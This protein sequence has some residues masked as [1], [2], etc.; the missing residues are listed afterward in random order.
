[1]YLL[2]VFFYKYRVLSISLLVPHSH[3]N[4]LIYQ[5]PLLHLLPFSRSVLI[6]SFTVFLSY[7]LI[8]MPGWSRH[9]LLA[10]RVCPAS[11]EL[12]DDDWG[13]CTE[14]NLFY[15]CWLLWHWDFALNPSLVAQMV[16][17][18]PQKQEICVSSLGQEDP[19]DKDM[20]TQLHYSCLQNPMDRGAWQSMGLQ[21][22]TWPS[23]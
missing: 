7:F 5:W 20:A 15:F 17:N 12:N 8:L 13:P 22:Q 3:M 16:K 19:L 23:D 21:S 9:I 11:W 14:F 1:M 18:L 2:R 10:L 4:Q 6:F